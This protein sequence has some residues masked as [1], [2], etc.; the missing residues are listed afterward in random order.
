MVKP[1]LS[2]IV[3]GAPVPCAR[4]R[5]QPIR[6]RDGKTILRPYTPPETEEYEQRVSMFA[7][8]ALQQRPEW[9][10]VLAARLPLRAHLHFVRQQWRGDWD[11]FAKGV[12]DGLQKAE[13]VF[14]NDN[15]ITQ[16][17]VSIETDKRAEPRTEV[18]IET[19]SAT[20]TEPL[21]QRCALE[22]GWTPPESTK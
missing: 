4:A 2:F 21:W 7:R 8:T 5:L 3:P 10:N 13:R 15:R 6:T 20:L 22:A 16:A 11:N 9:A 18:L 14:H 1:R 19:A 12:C 17:L